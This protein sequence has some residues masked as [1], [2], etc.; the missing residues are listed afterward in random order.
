MVVGRSFRRNF[1]L[2]KFLSSHLQVGEQYDCSN[3][4]LAGRMVTHNTRRL[5]KRSPRSLL[6]HHCGTMCV[7]RMSSST[8]ESLTSL[9]GQASISSSPKT[10]DVMFKT[11][12][13]SRAC[14][15]VFLTLQRSRAEEAANDSYFGNIR[16]QIF[17]VPPSSCSELDLW[18]QDSDLHIRVD[19]TSYTDRRSYSCTF[20]QHRRQSALRL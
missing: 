5:N 12:K 19:S 15:V 18:P 9:S 13:G 6:L 20:F 1:L 7:N 16:L 14:L 2:N 10:S 17:R 3:D 8:L 11:K 4:Q